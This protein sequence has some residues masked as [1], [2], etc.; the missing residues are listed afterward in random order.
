MSFI[1][2]ELVKKKKRGQAHSRDELEF[3]IRGY[4]RGEVPDYQMSAWLM[5]VCFQG[6]T[7]EETADLTL[8]MR[9]SGKVFDFSYLPEKK[10]DKHS[11]GGVGDKTTL[12]LAP[13]V[14][15][16]GIK[17]PMIAGRGL[18]HT[19]GTLDK[20]VSLNGF[21]VDLSEEEF[22]RQVEDFGAAIMG[23]TDHICPAD[24]KLYAL[25][26][27][28]GT[29]D[30][31]P[32]ICASIMSKKMAEGLDGLVLDV[33]F[34]SGAFMKTQAQAVAL[35]QLLR[36]TGEK[37]GIRVAAL[38]TD[39]NQP[40]GRYAGNALEVQEC[41]DILR[42]SQDLPFYDETRELSLKLAGYMIWLGDK[43][44][45]PEQGY[46]MAK[47]QLLSG[48]AF[49]YFVELCRRQG[50]ASMENLPA[51]KHVLEITA[52]LEGYLSAMDTEKIGLAAIEL[53]VGRRTTT[54]SIDLAAGIEF[55][56]KVGHTVR[57]GQMIAKL[58]AEDRQKLFA[59]EQ[60]FKEALLWQEHVE[61]R[62]HPP[63][64]A[65]VLA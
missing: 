58:Y 56:C 57:R 6:M 49:K 4:A 53:G 7:P 16:L 5:A 50:C 62:D 65:E 34:G 3:L 22:R 43:A 54:D 47:A 20:L 44:N 21:R 18:G 59:G 19:G 36:S 64:V 24:K 37:N 42:Q 60:L 9:D 12:I 52:E 39:M 35:A 33:K 55:F 29:V 25:R 38:I 30:S 46:Q 31:F 48:Q 17:V 26:D 32:L 11:T 8:I 13:I 23:Q 14:G 2:A 45:T 28:T 15:S 41:L 10:I 27:V 40:L 61:K 1:P 63:L 51:A